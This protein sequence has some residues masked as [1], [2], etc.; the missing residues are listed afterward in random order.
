MNFCFHPYKNV[1]L[2]FIGGG[3]EQ[4]SHVEVFCKCVCGGGD[5]APRLVILGGCTK[6][7]Q[8]KIYEKPPCLPS[9]VF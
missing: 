1:V 9:N 6:S 2:P 5:K 3:G 4:I 7:L 8:T